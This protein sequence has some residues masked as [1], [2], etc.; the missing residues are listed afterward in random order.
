MNT[1]KKPWQIV[2]AEAE[3]LEERANDLS[4]DARGRFFALGLYGAAAR[5]FMLAA[6]LRLASYKAREAKEIEG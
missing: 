4:V 5:L 6:E 3:L 1:E 2:Q